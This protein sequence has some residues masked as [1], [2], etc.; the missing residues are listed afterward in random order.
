MK[1]RW[2]QST[3]KELDVPI[4][5]IGI[6]HG[7]DLITGEIRW[8]GAAQLRVRITAYPNGSADGLHTF[9]IEWSA[10]ESLGLSEIVNRADKSIDDMK[11]TLDAYNA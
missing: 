9:I 4:F 7:H 10:L 2:I 1:Y 3:D 11:K 6:G 5:D 8:I